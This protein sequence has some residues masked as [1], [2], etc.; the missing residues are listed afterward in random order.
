VKPL[1]IS[2]PS[3]F[4]EKVTRGE[5]KRGEASLLVF[6]PLPYQGRGIKGEGSQINLKGGEVNKKS[7]T[8]PLDKIASLE[9]SLALDA[10]RWTKV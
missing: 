7:P 8:L 10:L 5:S 6:F 3:P 4:K 2:S 1:F 9:Y